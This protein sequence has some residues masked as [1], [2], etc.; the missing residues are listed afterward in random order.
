M[1]HQYSDLANNYAKEVNAISIA[2]GALSGELENQFAMLQGLSQKL[3]RLED[4]I[5]E[6]HA[7]DT[8]CNE[9]G[10]DESDRDYTVY[11]VD[12]LAF[13]AGLVKLAIQKKGAFIENQ[14]AARNMTNVTPQQ[15]EEFETSFRAFDKDNS[16]SLSLNEF[17]GVLKSLGNLAD[18]GRCRAGTDFA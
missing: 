14:I 16:N 6:L 8:L 2:L 15:L 11:S 3:E 12:D 1:R 4:M 9:A 10:I 5:P 17:K 13:D 7:A 18:V